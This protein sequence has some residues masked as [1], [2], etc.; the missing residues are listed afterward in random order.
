MKIFWYLSVFPEKNDFFYNFFR[1]LEKLSNFLFIK[2]KIPFF[3]GF[4]RSD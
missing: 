2:E 4:L 3:L 1:N